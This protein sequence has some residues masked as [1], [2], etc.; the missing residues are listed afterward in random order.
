MQI[1][2]FIPNLNVIR[3]VSYV[4]LQLPRICLIA[5][6]NRATSTLRSSLE[7]RSSLDPRVTVFAGERCESR[8]RNTGKPEPSRSHVSLIDSTA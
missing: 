5:S 7:T 4:V 3:S 8:L 6:C 2:L 1:A